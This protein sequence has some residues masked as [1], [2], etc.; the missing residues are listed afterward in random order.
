MRWIRAIQQGIRGTQG[1]LQETGRDPQIVDMLAL[2]GTAFPDSTPQPQSTQQH[3]GEHGEEG[4]GDQQ[5]QQGKAMVWPI[6]GWRLHGL[7]CHGASG[8]GT[9]RMVVKV[10]ACTFAP[11]CQ[12]ISVEMSIACSFADGFAT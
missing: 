2:F 5:L 8:C 3:H 11:S 1:G 4:D 6:R 9:S 7:P 12:A 10:T